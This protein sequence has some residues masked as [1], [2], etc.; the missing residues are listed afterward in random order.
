MPSRHGL[1]NSCP[2]NMTNL[3]SSPA[4][5]TGL[6]KP[7]FVPEK[8][9]E[10]FPLDT[11]QLPPAY[12]E[13]DLDDFA[14]GGKTDR[15]QS[16]L[17]PHS[18]ARSVAS[19]DPRLSGIH[20]LCRRYVGT[21]IGCLGIGTESR[22]HH[23]CVV[24]RSRLAPGQQTTLAKIHRLARRDTS[25]VDDTS[26]RI[27]FR[28]RYPLAHRLVFNATSQSIWLAFFPHLRSYAGCH[29]VSPAMVQV[30]YLC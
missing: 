25:S 9:F 7:W 3:S 15:S 4:G 21:R 12:L 19:R 1:A 11:I 13:S 5:F 20:P 24:E 30:S 23:C 26:A 17:C 6:T 18:R 22:Q 14:T 2:N 29:R 27:D 10:P 16:V 28:R 8:Y